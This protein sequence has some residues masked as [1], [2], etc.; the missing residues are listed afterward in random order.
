VPELPDIEVYLAHL[1]RRLLGRSLIRL[2]LVSPFILRTVEP[3]PAR[4]E[5][6]AVVGARR[7]GKRVVLEFEQ[8]LFAVLHLMVAGRLQWLEPGATLHRKRTH[9]GMH[10]EH[11]ILQLTE[12]GTKK[13]ASLH[14]VEG[15]E[16]LAVHQPGGLEVLDASEEEFVERL[17][18]SNHTLKR[19]LTDPRIFSGIGNA[20]SDEI[21]HAARL[22]PI[23]MSTKLD[24]EAARSLYEATRATLIEWTQRLGV[25]EDNFPKKVTAF[26]PDMAVHGRHGQPCPRCGD[27]VQRI[28]YAS[29]ETNYCATC[30]TGGRVLA[31]RSLSRLLKGDWPRS[32]E[33]LEALR[34]GNRG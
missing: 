6:R 34:S 17:R 15:E 7:L 8:E 9:L 21:L 33:E 4:F 27:P 14:L 22:S 20:Y 23:S 10:F 19:S 16:G 24:D 31:D 29:R 2:E 11:G 18:A 1:R 13:R 26:R 5:G 32:L 12:A 25:D 3:A 28:R 30:Q